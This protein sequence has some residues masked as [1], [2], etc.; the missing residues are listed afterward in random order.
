MICHKGNRQTKQQSTSIFVLFFWFG[1]VISLSSVF[2]KCKFGESTM[3]NTYTHKNEV[4]IMMMHRQFWSNECWDYHFAW[5]LVRILQFD[6][7]IAPFYIPRF[8]LSIRPL[9]FFIVV[10]CNF[11]RWFLFMCDC[12][13][14]CS[15]AS[16]TSLSQLD[17]VKKKRKKERGE[18]SKR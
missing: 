6:L 12:A 16:K 2:T 13:N 14:C 11:I 10:Q 5:H 3:Y 1:F 15:R 4:A 7:K 9:Y 18:R 8:F 17:R